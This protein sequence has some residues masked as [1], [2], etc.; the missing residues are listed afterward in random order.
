MEVY[1]LSPTDAVAKI[2]Q[3]RPN[4]S[5]IVGFMDQLHVYAACDY[6]PLNQPV[7]SH[8][9]LRVE[10]ETESV[11]PSQ[12]LLTLADSQ[13]PHQQKVLAKIPLKI[14]Y[15]I[16]EPPHIK[17]AHCQKFLA[18]HTS[19]LPRHGNSD[20][21]YLAQPMDWMSPEFD[22]R[23]LEGNFACPQCENI[24][25]EYDWSGMRN[26]SDWWISPAFVLHKNAVSGVGCE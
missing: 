20:N 9:R 19:V 16:T 7:Y 14:P 6:L 15:V 5:P 21:F 13:I 12:P 25:G 17:C 18:P 8:W 1:G 23:E 26:L 22:N 10:C 2:R 11:Y 4:V 24:V 3:S